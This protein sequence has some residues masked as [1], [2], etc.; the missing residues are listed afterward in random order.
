MHSEI[1][2]ICGGKGK[3]KNTE[4]TAGA[5]IGCHGCGGKGWIEVRNDNSVGIQP[6]PYYP[7][8][9]LPPIPNITYWHYTIC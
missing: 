8:P 6:Q 5:E 9:W 2:P 7:T 3:V 4:P 1:C